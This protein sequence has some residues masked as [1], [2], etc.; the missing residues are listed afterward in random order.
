MLKVA[1]ACA[2]LFV[3][4]SATPYRDCGSTAALTA[5]RVPGCNAL[6]CIVYR[7][8][9][10]TVEYDFTAVDPSTTLTTDVKGV[11]SGATLPWPGQF[12]P[13][14]ED[15]KVGDCPVAVAEPIT[16]AT[17]LV[18][19]PAF[20]SVNAKAIWTLR[21]DNDGPIVCF[22]VTVTLL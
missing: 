13:A 4:V 6:P 1:I 12:P 7:G 21:N 10:V 5:V 16:M 19:S 2:L 3:A 22:E 11:I 9:N 8:T 15:V 18:L 17:V 20:P 14:C